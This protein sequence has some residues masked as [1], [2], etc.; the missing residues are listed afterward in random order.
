MQEQSSAVKVRRGRDI[1]DT[2]A[3]G[4]I[5]FGFD[6]NSFEDESSSHYPERLEALESQQFDTQLDLQY[7]EI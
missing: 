5:N 3:P 6:S 1:T 4:I 2:V 7:K